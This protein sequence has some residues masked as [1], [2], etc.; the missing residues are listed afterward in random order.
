MAS[1]AMAVAAR[2][3]GLSHATNPQSMT[4]VDHGGSIRDR[5]SDKRR[6]AWRREQLNN[7]NQQSRN[8]AS[9]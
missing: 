1:L 8:T 6:L 5:S 4:I 3:M 9:K 2:I 7:E